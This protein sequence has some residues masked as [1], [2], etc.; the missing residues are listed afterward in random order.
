MCSKGKAVRMTTDHKGIEPTEIDRVRKV[1][2][3]IINGRVGGQLAVTRSLGDFAMKN[4]GV[5]SAPEIQ[6]KQVFP[7]DEFV[8]IAT[9][10]LW[11]VVDDQQAI[12]IVK[13]ENTQSDGAQK[14]IQI[15]MDSGSTDNITVM[16]INLK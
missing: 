4:C 15:A 14:L 1:G 11:D 5:T 8:I 7:G 9:D 13:D 6:R 2:G 10:G 16:I 3:H 12:D